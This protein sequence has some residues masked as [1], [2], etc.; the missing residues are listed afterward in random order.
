M[1]KVV[2]GFTSPKYMDE[3]VPSYGVIRKAAGLHT[4]PVFVIDATDAPDFGPG[5]LVR[6]S[7]NGGWRTVE[8]IYV[9]EDGRWCVVFADG[10]YDFADD[11]EKV[12]KHKTVVLKVTGPEH[13][14]ERV[15]RKMESYDGFPED[16]RIERV[17]EEGS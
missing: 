4:R 11:W 5:D 15:A 16:V 7:R 13:N 1:T 9:D 14:A 2:K 17:E 10:K 6:R 12:P 8:G 3:A